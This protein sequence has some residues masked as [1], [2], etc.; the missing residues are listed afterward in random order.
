MVLH[1]QEPLQTQ[2]ECPSPLPAA[3]ACPLLGVQRSSIYYWTDQKTGGK[4]EL[5]KY[6]RLQ[7]SHLLM[8]PFLRNDA[9]VQAA[10]EVAYRA[11]PLRP[12]V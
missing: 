9:S 4:C 12:G 2:A 10:L 7:T 11:L 6:L 5:R 3:V 8:F 1:P